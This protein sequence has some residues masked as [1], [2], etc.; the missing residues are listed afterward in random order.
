[1]LNNS[2]YYSLI[3]VVGIKDAIYFLLILIFSQKLGFRTIL[4]NSLLKLKLK[5]SMISF[6]GKTST[7]AKCVLDVDDKG[8]RG[9]ASCP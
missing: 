9:L 2:C 7:S 6:F 5:S 8:H 1:M 4:V 3:L